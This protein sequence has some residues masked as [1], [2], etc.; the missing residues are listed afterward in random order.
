[1]LI[2]RSSFL[3]AYSGTLLWN[4]V[5]LLIAHILDYT[6]FWLIWMQRGIFK[7]YGTFCRKASWSIIHHAGHPTFAFHLLPST[8]ARLLSG[9]AYPMAMESGSTSTLPFSSS[10]K[11]PCQ[12][13]APPMV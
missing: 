10:K 7:R 13:P 2:Y 9:I 1:M 6:N 11:S 4:F 8:F 12:Q 5:A 3:F